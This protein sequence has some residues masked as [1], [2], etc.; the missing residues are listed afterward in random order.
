LFFAFR[1]LAADSGRVVILMIAAALK[2]PSKK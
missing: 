2:R 1:P